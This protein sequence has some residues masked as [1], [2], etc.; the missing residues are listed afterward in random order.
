[1]ISQNQMENNNNQTPKI[2]YRSSTNKVIFG[3]CGGL[4]EY[5][6]IDPLL[7]RIIFIL[8]VL[9]AG[10]G[11]LVYL[12]LAFLIPLNPSATPAPDQ[13]NNIDVKKRVQELMS[14]LRDLR[15]SRKDKRGFFRLILG[16]IVLAIGF[17]LLIQNLNLF[18]GF[19]INFSLFFSYLW[20]VVI[21]LLGLSILSRALN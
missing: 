10:S 13:G 3:V 20:P 2:L 5:F 14:E 19:Y 17:G 11:I 4:G 1:M 18:P 21:I 12:V 9:G 16:L 8:L 15:R 7:F 6:N